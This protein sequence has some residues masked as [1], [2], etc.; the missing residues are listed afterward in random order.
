M[1]QLHCFPNNFGLQTFW[2]PC[3]HRSCLVYSSCSS[4][5]SFAFSFLPTTPRDIA[6]AVQLAVPVIKARR[7]L[8]PPSHFTVHFRLPLINANHG[9]SRHARRTNKKSPL[10]C[11][12]PLITSPELHHQNTPVVGNLAL[13]VL[14][15]N[16]LNHKEQAHLILRELHCWLPGRY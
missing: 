1:L 13:P 7:G 16:T 14:N 9:A 12:G 6:V 11:S 10:H 3:P 5:Q 15:L 4:G 2:P 8:S